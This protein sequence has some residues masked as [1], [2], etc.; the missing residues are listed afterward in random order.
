VARDLAES[1]HLLVIDKLKVEGP[2]EA[3]AVGR[4]LRGLVRGGCWVA[5]TVRRAVG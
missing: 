4:L 1:C 2:A 3:T 5:F